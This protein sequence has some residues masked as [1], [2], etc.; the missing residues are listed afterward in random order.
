MPRP[1][2]RRGNA[3]PIAKASTDQERGTT[4]W[5]TR[6]QASDLLG[7]SPATIINWERS[8]R[9]AGRTAMR[10]DL[11]GAF[12]EQVVYD[13]AEII[14]LPRKA[15]M[16]PV[17]KDPD[18]LAARVTEL[19]EMGWTDAAIVLELRVAYD[20]VAMIREMWMDAGGAT[21]MLTTEIKDALAELIGPFD[22][23]AQMLERVRVELLDLRAYKAKAAA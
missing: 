19:V 1:P 16:R 2:K 6:N 17:S 12:Y 10:M 8:G 9:I 21:Q 5:I 18:E 15:L 3:K 11:R 7:V 23:A 14:K 22:T 13:P 20:R 4:G